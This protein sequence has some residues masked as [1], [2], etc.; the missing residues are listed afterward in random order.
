VALPRGVYSARRQ[1]TAADYFGRTVSILAISIPSFWLGTMVMIYPSIWWDWSPPVQY[2]A[3]VDNPARNLAQ[4]IIPGTILGMVLSGS[5]MRMT[6]TMMLEVLRQDY[7]RSAWA[8]GLNERTVIM[9]HALKN[10]LIPVTTIVGLQASILIGGSVILEQIFCLPGVGYYM[11]D[12][13]T[14]RDYP[15]ISGVN[16]L[17]ASFV[18]IINLV[19]DLAYAYLDPRISYQ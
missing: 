16:V 14:N 7:V 5:T 6:R 12:A 10:A 13:I 17:M 4:F 3:F 2:I 8:K 11:L 15:V 19:V 1:D 18:L 9:R